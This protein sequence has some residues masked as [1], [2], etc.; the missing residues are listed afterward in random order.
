MAVYDG[1]L[2][3]GPRGDGSFLS[4]M[5]RRA[6]LVTL[7]LVI[8]AVVLTFQWT[9][10]PIAFRS[11]DPAVVVD[12]LTPLVVASTF[13]E[14]A[15]EVVLSVWRSKEGTLLEWARDVAPPE[16]RPAIERAL[17]EY[18]ATSHRLAMKGAFVLGTFLAA[19]GVRALEPFVAEGFWE[20]TARA[21]QHGLFTA[22]DVLVTGAV[23]GGGAEGIHRLVSV[24]LDF[25]DQT[26]D[27]INR[28]A[29]ASATVEVTRTEDAG[30]ERRA[31]ST[32][33][34]VHD[35]GA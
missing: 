12:R 1:V 21:W 28:P 11:I 14:R 23:I 33:V 9:L 10:A 35:P 29:G 19:V 13:V 2:D 25:L 4:S 26:R 6:A 34:H 15:V 3:R 7:V 27:R 32:T 8:V 22:L 20:E 31:V 5:D 24:V 18:K 17:L 30:P 16:R